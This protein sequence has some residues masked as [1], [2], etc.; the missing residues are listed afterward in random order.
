MTRKTV[1]EILATD[2]VVQTRD[3]ITSASI[4]ELKEFIHTGGRWTKHSIMT[5]LAR[6]ELAIRAA[7]ASERVHWTITPGFIVG[8]LAMLFAAIAA[9]PTVRE[10]LQSVPPAHT[11]ASSQSPPSNSVP[12]ILTAPKTVS[13]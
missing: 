6:A 11:D 8:V 4:P 9:W 3:W 13:H 10:W 1:Q 12:V 2:D 7:E 5:D